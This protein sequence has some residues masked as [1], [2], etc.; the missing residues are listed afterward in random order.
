[1]EL[2]EAENGILR[3]EIHNILSTGKREELPQ[4]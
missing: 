2:L 1:M 3:F 4:Q